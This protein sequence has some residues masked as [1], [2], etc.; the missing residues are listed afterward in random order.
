MIVNFIVRPILEAEEAELE[1]Q[2]TAHQIQAERQQFSRSLVFNTAQ[3]KAKLKRHQTPIT[4]DGQRQ[5]MPGTKL[6]PKEF[7]LEIAWVFKTLYNVR[8]EVVGGAGDGGI[9]VKVD[10]RPTKALQLLTWDTKN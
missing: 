5:I 2:Q 9:D 3:T 6:S 10:N 4:P 7:E 8:T 1:E